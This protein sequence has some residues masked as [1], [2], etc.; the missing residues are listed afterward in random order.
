MKRGKRGTKAVLLAACVALS[1]AQ[2]VV[3]AQTA[4][5]M[6]FD[7]VAD[8]LGTALT[9]VARQ[10]NREI[11]FSADLTRD[12]RAP[13]LSGAL[14]VEEALR[15]L[16]A[17]SGLTYR[18]GTG[19]SIIVEPEGTVKAPTSD[20]D[21]GREEVDAIVV[22]GYR[23]SLQ[24][25]ADAKKNA[26]NF[27]DSIFA[28]DVGKFPDFNLTESLQRLPGVQIDR[29][30]SGEGT[31]INVRGLSAGFTVLTLNG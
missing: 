26:T 11:Y 3:Q 18:I 14:T 22:T 15:R 30:T 6:Q 24:D 25:S 8:D 27:T 16:L 23:Q 2:S 7:I 20:V 4:P 21:P 10:S 17:G 1:V 29:D 5:E 9:Q 19:D 12:K 13:K 28:E 31:Y